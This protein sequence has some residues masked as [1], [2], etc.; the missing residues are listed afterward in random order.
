MIDY[1]EDE[2]NKPFHI[3]AV[4]A[5][6][7]LIVA[8]CGPSVATTAAPQPTEAPAAT[9]A[10]GQDPTAEAPAATEAPE[11]T[12]G[13]PAEPKVLRV[14]F[15]NDMSN[16][17]PA[18]HPSTI[19]TVIAETVLEGLV[20]YKPG[21]WELENVLAE[22]I[23]QSEDGLRIDFKLKEGVMFH[24]DYGE[25]TAEDVKYSNERQALGR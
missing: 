14:R 4:L 15:T 11:P 13:A 9:A 7:G 23:E 22:S 21:T 2:M 8:A 6:I 10:E 5:I 12:A 19:D 25:M 18:F 3:V 20:T 1:G 24:G 17:D 16:A